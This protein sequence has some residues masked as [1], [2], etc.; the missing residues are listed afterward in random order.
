MEGQKEGKG[1]EKTEEEGWNKGKR[2]LTTSGRRNGSS[3]GQ[4]ENWRITGNSSNG[5]DE[6][7]RY[8]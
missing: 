4:N 1:E 2:E 7:Y 5:G 3:E 8:G 6:L